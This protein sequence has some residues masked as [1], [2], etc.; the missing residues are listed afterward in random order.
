MSTG[1]GTAEA[2]RRLAGSEPI[3]IGM[4]YIDPSA[5]YLNEF[6]IGL[7]NKASLRHVQLVVQRCDAARDGE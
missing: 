7:L 6:L 2:A 5:G 1:L 4:L 3:R